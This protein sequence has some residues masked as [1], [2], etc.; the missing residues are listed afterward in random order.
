[1]K[2]I[3]NTLIAWGPLGVFIIAVVDG[4]GVPSPGGLDWVILLLSANRPDLAFG[5]A[6]LA[7]LGSMIGGVFL[8]WIA[9]RGGDAMLK[10]YR[11]RPRFERFERWFQH[12]GMLTVFIPALVPI[13]MPLK[14]FI[15]CA[16]VF[17]VPLLTY[18]L[19]LLVARIPRYLGLAYLGSQLG[20]QSF[21]WLKAHAWHM[22]GIAF[23]LFV[24]LY[25]LILVA[26]RRR[27]LTGQE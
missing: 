7:I 14:F 5:L 6:G 11:G 26:D 21:P 15:I 1:M 17:E 2:A 22:I 20:H 3:L 12:Y 19:V 4:A 13:P 9:R 25:L 24:F 18:F 8:Y 10:K 27:R 16:G 23:G